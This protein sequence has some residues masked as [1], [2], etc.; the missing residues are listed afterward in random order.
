MWDFI[1]C[2]GMS[3]TTLIG[4]FLLLALTLSTY[5]KAEESP[6]IE[7]PKEPV[8]VQDYVQC[9]YKPSPSDEVRFMCG[10][11]KEGSGYVNIW[12]CGQRYTFDI[13]CPNNKVNK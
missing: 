6:V 13:T 10:T 4:G 5:V 1:K 7:Q 9:T 3:L 11:I 2:L 12:I 8:I